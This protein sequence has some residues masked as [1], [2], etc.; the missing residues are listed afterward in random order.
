MAQAEVSPRMNAEHRTAGNGAAAIDVRLGKIPTAP[1]DARGVG[2]VG[3]GAY[4]LQG[5]AYEKRRTELQQMEVGAAKEPSRLQKVTG[6]LPLGAE[7]A[8]RSI[9]NALK[10]FATDLRKF[11]LGTFTA[12]VA[13]D[14]VEDCPV[15]HV[16]AKVQHRMSA[17]FTS[18]N[19]L[20]VMIGTVIAMSFRLQQQ[21]FHNPQAVLRPLGAAIEV[22]CCSAISYIA[23]L[24]PPL[25]ARRGQVDANGCMRTMNV[26]CVEKL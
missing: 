26:F 9:L 1:L 7:A 25:C 3:N 21:L 15:G 17:V 23:V 18:P 19:I 13:S 8:Q 6:V 12:R 5:G 4:T 11:G 20:A 16:W 14:V 22:R 10:R 24:P 2:P